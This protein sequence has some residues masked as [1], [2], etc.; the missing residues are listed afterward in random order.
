MEPC[1]TEEW[2]HCD[3]QDGMKWLNCSEYAVSHCFCVCFLFPFWSPYSLYKLYYSDRYLIVYLST[4]SSVEK[5]EV[6]F[7]RHLPNVVELQM[8][9][10]YWVL[11]RLPVLVCLFNLNNLLFCHYCQYS[12]SIS[13]NSYIYLERRC[14]VRD[15]WFV[16]KWKQVPFFLRSLITAPTAL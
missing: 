15:D 4:D 5:F 7:S 16:E 10:L 11:W 1:G 13:H 9:K 3:L 14:F 6:L 12:S 2:H 8:L